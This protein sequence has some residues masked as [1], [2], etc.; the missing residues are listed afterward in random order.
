MAGERRVNPSVLASV[1]R[2]MTIS[3]ERRRASIRRLGAVAL[4]AGAIVPGSPSPSAGRLISVGLPAT[5]ALVKTAAFVQA[6]TAAAGRTLV[7]PAP[8]TPEETTSSNWSG[9]VETN[10]PFT[11]ITGTFVVPSVTP[12]PGGIDRVGMGRRR[13]VGQ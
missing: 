8:T 6:N 2:F 11:A 3:S 5:M 9:Y 4:V 1:V 13:R 10:G 12:V 7:S